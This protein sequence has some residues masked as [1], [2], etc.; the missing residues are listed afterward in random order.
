M[1]EVHDRE[2]E[3]NAEQAHPTSSVLFRYGGAIALAVVAIAVRMV[4]ASWHSPVHLIFYYAAVAA[5]AWLFDFGPAVVTLGICFALAAL[6]VGSL[7][8]L[9][10]EEAVSNLL[11][12]AIKFTPGSGVIEVALSDRGATAQLRRHRFRSGN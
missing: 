8:D 3:S 6:D 5:S 11:T 2:I 1:A 7:R 9:R 10:I 4:V 12:N